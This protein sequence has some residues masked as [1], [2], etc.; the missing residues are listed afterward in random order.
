M[1]GSGAGLTTM[2]LLDTNVVSEMRKMRPHGGV[3]QWL[4]DIGEVDLHL[5]AVTLAEIQKGIEIT[6]DQDAEKAAEI[7]AW[8]ELL[9]RS[10]NVIPMDSA[11][12]RLWAK[13][14]HRSSD[15]LYEDAM[16]AA[17]AQVHRLTVV[18]RNVSDFKSF[19]VETLDPF[20]TPRR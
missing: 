5:S 6:R 1:E 7:E 2:Y 19:G 15:S 8:L 18:T 13:L 10:Y 9:T 12:F 17:T 16:L 3:L 11:A 20:K 4:S 14:M